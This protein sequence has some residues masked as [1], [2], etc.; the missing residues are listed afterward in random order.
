[1]KNRNRGK[2]DPDIDET[3]IPEDI[4][5]LDQTDVNTINTL[6][7]LH[8]DLESPS[9]LEEQ[10]EDHIYEPDRDKAPQEIHDIYDIEDLDQFLTAEVLL[11]QNGVHMKAAKVL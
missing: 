8:D 4:E 7:W 10:Y 11:P 9:L 5:N 2:F 6:L 1:M 3:N